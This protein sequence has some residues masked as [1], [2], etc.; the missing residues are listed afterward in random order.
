MWYTEEEIAIAKGVDLVKVAEQLGYT[1]ER[2]GRYYT[3]KEMDS[4]RIH[5]R[6]TWCR[7]SRRGEKQN[8]GGSQIDFLR[9]FAGLEF[10]EAVAWLLDFAG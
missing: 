2:K 3:V 7:W 9:V 1:I 4:I 6:R 8:G 5:D 10:T